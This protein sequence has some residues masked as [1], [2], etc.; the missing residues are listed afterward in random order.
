MWRCIAQPTE[1]SGRTS[2]S[3]TSKV[4]QFAVWEFYWICVC[5]LV[6]QDFQAKVL[7]FLIWSLESAINDLFESVMGILV[8]CTVFFVSTTHT[9]KTFYTLHSQTH[10]KSNSN[11]KQ[12]LMSQND[13]DLD[14]RNIGAEHPKHCLDINYLFIF[15]RIVPF[16]RWLQKWVN[17]VTWSSSVQ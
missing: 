2:Q 15:T 13:F 1:Q 14:Q 8:R 7:K 10:N 12:L 11:P 9:I 16:H 5:V 3:K 17:F 4:S 6:Y